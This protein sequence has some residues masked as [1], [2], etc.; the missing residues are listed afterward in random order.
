MIATPRIDCTRILHSAEAVLFDNIL[1]Y[2]SCIPALFMPGAGEGRPD[3]AQSLLH[4]LALIEER[5]F[6]DGQNERDE[7]PAF[8]QRVEAKLDL[9]L[10]LLGRLLEQALT[11]PGAR[12]V[13]WSIRGARIEDPEAAD[14][15]IGSAGILQ[16][17]PCDWLP[18]SLELPASVFAVEPGHWTWMR[19]P[20]FAPSLHDALERHLF[21]LHR[22]QIALSRKADGKS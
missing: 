2:E 9:N 10:L 11:P 19:F 21:R 14:A 5:G 3:H 7:Q 12:V 1:S 4:S 20:T 16:I 8:R 17:Q 6:E 13:R 22:R 15:L 18:E